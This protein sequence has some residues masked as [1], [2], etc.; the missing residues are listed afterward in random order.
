[1]PPR[2]GPYGAGCSEKAGGVIEP[3]NG[4]SCGHQEIPQGGFAGQADE[5]HV[6][7]GRSPGCGMARSEDTTGVGERGMAS[8]GGLGN[9]G[10]PPVSLLHTRTGGPGDQKP[11]RDLGLPPGPR[12]LRGHH[13][14]TEA[15][16]V[17]GRRATSEAPRDEQGG[18]RSGAYSRRRWGSEAQATHGREGAVGPSIHWGDTGERQG[19]HQP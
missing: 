3:R 12:A 5:L 10:E 9:L 15:G 8:E 4:E 13:E 14:H 7:E 6:P 1:M 2:K 17:S 19:A 11:W 16:K 18:S